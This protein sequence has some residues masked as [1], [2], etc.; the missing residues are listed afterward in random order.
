MKSFVIIVDS[1]SDFTADLRERFDIADVLR[2]VVYF[3]DGR[4]E[5]A[6]VDWQNYTPEWYYGS[7]KERKVL[8][9][10]ASVPNG[11]AERVFEKHLAQGQDILYIALSSALSSNYQ[12]SKLVAQELL[13]KYPER[14]ICC[15]DSLRYSTA[16][17]LLVVMAS[18]QRAR[19][20]SLEE[21]VAFLEEKKHTIHQMGPM[22]DLFFLTKTGRISNF[23]AFFGTLAGVNPMADFNQKGLSQVVTKAKGKKT[24]LEATVRYM[25]KTLLEPEQQIIFIAHSNREAA[26]RQLA[27]MVQ[28][29][30]HP[31]EIILNPVGMSCGASI[32]PGLCAAFYV[33]RPISQDMKEENEIMAGVMAELTGKK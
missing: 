3:P 1:S 9:K 6:D 20:A 33:G 18:Q 15:V 4:E 26:A 10:T 23:K 19:G 12:S 5:L 32:G 29:R 17:S 14:K 31:K 30:L 28:E 16:L 21:T 24:A 2:G 27:Q 11:E 7:M 8:Y 13:K 22:D 25:E